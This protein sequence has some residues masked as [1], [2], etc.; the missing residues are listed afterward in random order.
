MKKDMTKGGVWKLIILFALP[1]MGTN[2]LQQL[3]NT[4]DTVVVGN[5]AEVSVPGSFAAVATSAPLTIL[6]LALS[7]GLGTGAAVVCSQL[8]GARREKDLSVA[9]D[10]A[11]ILLSIVGIAVMII[12]WFVTPILFSGVL[13]VKDPEILRLATAY[14][15]IYCIGLPFQ[16]LYNSVASVLRG[17]GDSKASLLFLLITSAANVVL[18]LWFVISFGW[19]VQGVAIATVISQMICAA[20]SYIYLRRKFPFQK[21]ERHFDKGLCRSIVRIGLPSAIQMGI[22]S[23]GNS[24]MMRLVHHFAATNVAGNAIIDAFGAGSQID[25]FVHVP[26]MGLQSALATFTG[27][28]LAAGRIDRVKRGYY[29]ALATA[30]VIAAILSVTIYFFAVPILRIFGLTD[31]ATGI[32]VEQIVFY[33]KIFWIFAL[34]TV[35]GGVLQGAGDTIVQSGATLFALFTR[36]ALAYAGVFIFDW[37][38]YQASWETLAYGWVLALVITNVRFYTGGWKKKVIARRAP[39]DEPDETSAIAAPAEGNLE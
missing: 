18:D 26:V 28:N 9:V 21:G 14:M 32:G 12:G 17:V 7:I 27:Q 20:V 15:R 29:S 25:F 37:F 23:A 11:M 2:L 16:F 5:F 31:S 19:G 34:Y 10:T 6:F 13:S 8:F 1:I 39:E 36:V 33:A 35:V 24:A 3:Y 30:A 38:G 4:V 22:V